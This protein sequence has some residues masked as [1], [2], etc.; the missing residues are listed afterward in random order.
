MTELFLVEQR[1]TSG[2]L[3]FNKDKE[4]KSLYASV[5]GPAEL[6]KPLWHPRMQLVSKYLGVL[7]HFEQRWAP[8]LAGRIRLTKV[9]SA[10]LGN[11]WQ[12]ND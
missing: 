10:S 5:K 8:E 6:C 7:H 1:D 11:F 3:V 12:L 4:K 2:K 9:A